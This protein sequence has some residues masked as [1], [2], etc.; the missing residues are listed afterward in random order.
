MG[1][2]LI[3]FP[4]ST[5]GGADSAFQ[6]WI[7]SAASVGLRARVAFFEDMAIR[8]NNQSHTAVLAGDEVLQP[9]FV[10]M[11]GYCTPLSEF[12]EQQGAKVVNS[13]RSMCVSRDKLLTHLTLSSAAIPTPATV[14][15]PVLPSTYSE[16]CQLMDSPRF[17]IKN[18]E[19]SKGEKVWLVS[20]KSSFAEAMEKCDDNILLQEYIESSHGRDLRLWIIGGKTVGAVL[21]HSDSD[22]RSNYALG[23]HATL[24]DPPYEACRLAEDAARATGLFFAGVDLLF[25]ETGFTVCEVNGN[26]GFRTLSATGGPDILK[27][28]FKTLHDSGPEIPCRS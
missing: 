18:R 1:Y 17:V 12:F 16:V 4:I 27:F 23:G 6:W 26:A 8:I 7:D 25:T 2:G 19:G 13:T 14:W 22:F 21:R 5:P 20:D 24:Y 15:C 28:F 3:L 10:V 11:R 9:D